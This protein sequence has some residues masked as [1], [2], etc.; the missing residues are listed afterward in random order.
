ML[1]EILSVRIP[2]VTQVLDK[3]LRTPT[4]ASCSMVLRIKINLSSSKLTSQVILTMIFRKLSCKNPRNKKKHKKWVPQRSCTFSRL[5]FQ[6][7]KSNHETRREPWSTKFIL[8]NLRVQSQDEPK[9]P[10]AHCCFEGT[11]SRQLR[12]VGPTC[13]YHVRPARYGY[14]C[15]NSQG[16]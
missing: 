13:S 11:A 12:F 4:V 7:E 9:E 1:P 2:S 10:Q 16:K 5:G 8:R 3:W 6:A 14:L 15:K